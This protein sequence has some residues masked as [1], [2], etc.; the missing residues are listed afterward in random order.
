MKLF[1]KTLED[2]VLDKDEILLYPEFRDIY[3]RDDSRTK[4]NAFKEFTYIYY[5]ADYTAYPSTKGFS[6]KE[7]HKYAIE[8]IKFDTGWKPDNKVKAAI[9]LY[10]ELRTG[11]AIDSYININRMLKTINDSISY[12]HEKLTDTID[13]LKT[14]Q[15]DDKTTIEQM[16]KIDDYIEVSLSRIDKLIDKSSKIPELIEKVKKAEVSA[17]TESLSS[18]LMRGQKIIPSSAMPNK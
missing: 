18:G 1:N 6:E 8:Q 12:I 16:A 7:A 2:L 11:I 17:K 13:S 14:M 10:K 4:L 5:I 9:V 3:K 15:I